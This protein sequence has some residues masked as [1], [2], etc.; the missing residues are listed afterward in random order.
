[1]IE[2][3]VIYQVFEFCLE[4]YKTCMSVH[5]NILCLFFS[6]REIMLNLTKMH[7]CYTFVT[8]MYSESNSIDHLHTE[9]V[10]T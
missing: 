2:R 9:L 4:K 5:L 1:M 6:T 7:G 3:R 10:Q 8:Q